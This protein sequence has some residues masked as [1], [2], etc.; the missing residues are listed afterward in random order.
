MAVRKIGLKVQD[1]NNLGLNGVARSILKILEKITSKL[2][3][4]HFLR[5]VQMI[6][7]V[8]ITISVH[9]TA[10]NL[11]GRATATTSKNWAFKCTSLLLRVQKFE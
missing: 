5:M 7:T 10:F 11:L 6:K 4:L 2:A 1:G 9:E 3:Q 8:F